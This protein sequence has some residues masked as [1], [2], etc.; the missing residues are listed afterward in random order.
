MNDFLDRISKLSPRRLMLLALELQAKVESLSHVHREPIAIIGIGCRFPGGADDPDSF[1]QLLR[2]GGDAVVDIPKHRWDPDASAAPRRADS[3]TMST[4]RGGFLERVDEFDPEFFGILPGEALSMDPQQRLVL[5]VGWEALEHAGIAADRLAGSRTGVF[6]GISLNDFS[7]IIAAAGADSLGGHAAS[8]S[9]L[10]VAAGRLSYVLGLNGPSLA[11]DTT[12][13]SSLVSIAVACD[14]LR[15]HQCTMALAGGVNVI[16][17]PETAAVLAQAGVLA[18]D[19]RC[20]TF[21]AAADGF[22]R[23]EGCGIVVLKR[24]SDAHADGDRILAVIRGTAI[25]QDGRSGG[26]TAPNGPAQQDLLREALDDAGL[27]PSDVRYVEA[28][29][30]GTSLGDPIEVQA[31]AAILGQGR[32]K[33]EALLLGSVKTN[34]GHLESAAGVAGLIKAVLAIEH[35][36]IPPHL[37]LNT[38]NPHIDWASLP[39]AVPTRVT[40]WPATAGSRIA[41]VSSFGLSGTNAH[42]ILEGPTTAAPRDAGPERPLHILCLSAR[43]EAALKA[44][45]GRYQRRLDADSSLSAADVCYTANS[46]RCHFAHRLTVVGESRTELSRQLGVFLAGMRAPGIAVQT[47]DGDRRDQGEVVFVFNDNGS[48]DGSQGRQLYETQPS[49]RGAIERVGEA[50]GCHIGGTPWDELLREGFPCVD[51]DGFKLTPSNRAAV[52]GFARQYALAELLRSW[53]IGPGPAIGCGVGEHVASC[54]RGELTLEQSLKRIIHDD[55]N[56]APPS[57]TFTAAIRKLH[58]DGQRIFLQMGP[59]PN[60]LDGAGQLLPDSESVWLPTLG[61][62][63]GDWS[64]LLDAVSELYLRGLALDWAGFDR[65]YPRRKVSLPTYPFERRRYWPVPQR[66]SAAAPVWKDWL[67]ELRWESETAPRCEFPASDVARSE[68]NVVRPAASG[69]WLIFGDTTGYGDRLATLLRARGETCTL[70]PKTDARS[71]DDGGERTEFMTSQF[72]NCRGVIDLRAVE[73]AIEPDDVVDALSETQ[74]RAC[75]CLLHLVQALVRAN[76]S[77]V[78]PLTVVTM[79]AQFTTG[80]TGAPQ[81]AQAPIWGLCRVV[82]LE[83]PDLRCLRIDL[84]PSSAVD[85]TVALCDEIVREHRADEVAF[86]DG[87]RFV[88]RLSPS[89]ATR[90]PQSANPIRADANYLVTGGLSGLGLATARWLVNQGARHLVLAG[91]RPPAEEALEVIR[92]LERAGVMVDVVQADVSGPDDVARLFDRI[93]GG[94]APLRGVFHCAGTLDDGVLLEQK[95]ARFESV[96]AAK[97]Q[98]AWNL[99]RATR[100]LPLECFV[101]YSSGASLLG[102][103]GQGNYAAANAFLDSLAHYRAAHGLPGLAINWGGWAQIGRAA[104]LDSRHSKRWASLGMGAIEP[105]Q[106]F[107]ALGFLMGQAGRQVAV[108][109]IDW[110]RCAEQSIPPDMLPPLLHEIAARAVGIDRSTSDGPTV[111]A[112]RLR[113]AA[114]EDRRAL[115]VEIVRDAVNRLFRLNRP[116]PIGP[117]ENLIALGMDSLTAI[118]LSNQLKRSL[119]LPLESMVAFD[120]PTIGDLADFLLDASVSRESTNADRISEGTAAKPVSPEASLA[121]DWDA[122]RAQRTLVGLGGLSDEEVDAMLNEINPARGGGR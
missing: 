96:M 112:V 32:T 27:R 31:L 48:H 79:G 29:G 17:R 103:P 2:R 88:P 9:S 110:S 57:G 92:E 109:P 44:L 5:E 13:S 25:N 70:I 122:Q 47:F 11:I 111:P 102:S 89:E 52:F 61:A 117:D 66:E 64:S 99:H 67:Y 106:G 56:S 119:D 41:G 107:E 39:V 100:N 19:G 71:V 34:L 108:L 60:I 82:A 101:L 116:T 120:H 20:K 95:W 59:S 86:R 83:H 62:E 28:H 77:P 91:R 21:D 7:H 50:L 74:S 81:P 43:S 104:K 65:D 72:K 98:G 45:A 69:S 51:A 10:A 30:T 42:V 15:A 53:G 78:P 55:R 94:R 76:A 58:A 90:E 63:R 84:D 114:P 46:G 22:V 18:R 8:G 26:L 115:L 105:T 36:E 37:H 23:G 38:P 73:E 40:P 85:Q 87:R 49:F 118:Q 24:L 35:A 68:L 6:I 16:L 75:R 54:V 1:W 97:V 3:H 80:Q 4:P 14:S 121:G 33:K 12:C 93:A 113:L